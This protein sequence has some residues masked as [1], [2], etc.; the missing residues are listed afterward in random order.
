MN[1]SEKLKDPRWQ[2]K[3]LEVLQRDD[4]KCKICFDGTKTLHVHHLEYIRRSEPWEVP[5]EY[6]ETLCWECHE[7]IESEK[8]ENESI[9]LKNCRL[10]MGL[11][12]DAPVRVFNKYKNIA[13]L[14]SLLDS[15]DE[16]KVIEV[17]RD[18]FQKQ[19][20]EL[21]NNLKNQNA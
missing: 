9:I 13:D 14:F 15:L 16:E 5:L 1:Y 2:K 21:I 19:V 18:V 10:K 3:R 7:Q 11:Y 12:L 6:L 4:F 20:D 17:L 8:H